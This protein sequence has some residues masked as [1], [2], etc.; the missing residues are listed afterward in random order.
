MDMDLDQA[1]L[2]KIIDTDRISADVCT[3]DEVF[4]KTD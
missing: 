1:Y 4:I 3:K 2:R